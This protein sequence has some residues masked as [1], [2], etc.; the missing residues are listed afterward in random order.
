MIGINDLVKEIKV[1]IRVGLGLAKLRSNL[2]TSAK[3][4]VRVGAKFRGSLLCS[5]INTHP[6]P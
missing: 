4:R 6:R 1:K 3:V 5:R 2:S